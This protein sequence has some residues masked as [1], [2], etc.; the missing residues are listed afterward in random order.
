MQHTNANNH[1]HTQFDHPRTG[2]ISFLSRGRVF[3]QKSSLVRVGSNYSHQAK[4]PKGLHSP[5][6]QPCS[7]LRP[8]SVLLP[9]EEGYHLE[10]WFL[11]TLVGRQWSRHLSPPPKKRRGGRSDAM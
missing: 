6:L 10:W 2:E 1:M 9:K 3:L 8:E 7:A 4:A 5:A 11:I